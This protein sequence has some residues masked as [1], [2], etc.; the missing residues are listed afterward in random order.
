M[1]RVAV[2]AQPG[3]RQ[4]AGEIALV[5]RRQHPVECAGADERGH[6]ER[7]EPAP[8]GLRAEQPGGRGGELGLGHGRRG[9]R[10]GLRVGQDLGEEPV[11]CGTRRWKELGEHAA[12]AGR[13]GDVRQHIRGG[14]RG[15][16]VAGRRG[17]QHRPNRTRCGCRR[18]SDWAIIPPI[19]Q[20]STSG[21]PRR[22]A[23][24]GDTA[25]STMRLI[26]SG[27]GPRVVRRMPS[28]SKTTTR[29]W[30][31]RA[32]TNDGGQASIVPDRPMISSSGRPSPTVR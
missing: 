11:A 20:P 17:A 27:S 31:A 26:V 2:Q 16:A 1:T 22:S 5:G 14:Q 9:G 3:A 25:P 18:A 7:A 29:R 19:D 13:V 4:P 32:S 28:L 30:R 24:I 10:A 15:A 12:R 21:R 6:P 8:G 23:R